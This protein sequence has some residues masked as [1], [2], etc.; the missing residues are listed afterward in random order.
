M[1]MGL[2]RPKAIRMSTGR[3]AG[4]LHGTTGG[5]PADNRLPPRKCPDGFGMASGCTIVLLLYA[6]LL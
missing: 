6:Y 5:Y 3:P 4:I 1:I 2:L